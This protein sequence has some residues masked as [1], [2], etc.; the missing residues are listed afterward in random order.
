VII[1]ISGR[2]RSGKDSAAKALIDQGFKKLSFAEP[3]KR[4]CAAALQLPFETF[5]SDELKEKQFDYPRVL[6]QAV[7]CDLVIELQLLGRVTAEQVVS[8]IKTGKNFV[9]E[10]PRDMLVFVGTELVRDIIGETFWINI[11]EEEIMKHENVVIT[12]C[13]FPNERAM[14]KG[15]GGSVV[16][17]NRDSVGTT[18]SNHRTE[19]SFGDVDE[20]DFVLNNDTTI[21]QLQQQLVACTKDVA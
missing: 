15:L 5:D 1:G 18:T 19:N 3:L 11:L 7:L 21:K 8:I 9:A 17:I 10:C 4:A 14:I 20:Y 6:T 12:D 2:K 16:L 13:R